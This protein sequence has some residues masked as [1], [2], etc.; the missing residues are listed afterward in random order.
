MIR[1]SVPVSSAL[2]TIDAIREA[3]AGLVG[4]AERTPL[5]PADPLA[6]LAGVPVFLKLENRQPTGAFKLR[7]A[8]T[9]VRRLP[10]DARRRGIITYSSGNH[11]QAV[12]F[13]AWRLGIRAV[14]V[15]PETAPSIKVAGVKRW[16]GEVE[17]AGTTSEDRKARADEL[18]AEQALTVIPPFAHHDVIAGQGTVGLEIIEDL[19]D[20]RHV[21]VPVGGGGL[22]A[23]ITTAITALAPDAAVTA[24][25]P[26]GAAAMGAALRAGRVVRLDRSESLADGLLPVAVGELNF[27]HVQG[28]IDAVTV[29]DEAIAAATGWLY[30]VMQL[31]V[32]PS[33]AA[34]TAAL[35]V[36]A[37]RPTGPTVLV[38]SGGN[39][40]PEQVRAFAGEVA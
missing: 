31:T 35:R 19:P 37:I 34:T 9:A 30:R 33:G 40:D 36:R 17:F 21:A 16:G 8:W 27:A 38:V 6:E 14:I 23:G 12:A 39:V 32:E 26:I 18:I 24:V 28:R 5:V 11:G 29:D 10:D 22:I 13:A 20:V 7:G 3:A 4:V 2:V 25:E 15:M 1:T